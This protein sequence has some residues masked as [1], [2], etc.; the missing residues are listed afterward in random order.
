CVVESSDE[1]P[2]WT[3]AD[4]AALWRSGLVE[5]VSAGPAELRDLTRNHPIEQLRIFVQLRLGSLLGVPIRSASDHVYG[6]LCAAYEKPAAWNVDDLEMLQ[7]FA[8]LAASDLELRRRVDEQD[9]NEQRLSY[10]ANHDAL[11]GLATRA[12]LLERLRVALERPPAPVTDAPAISDDRL[13]PPP[14]DLVAV[15]M[16]DVENFSAIS[17]RFGPQAGDQVLTAIAGRLRRA[18]GESLVARCGRDQFAVLVERLETT[19]AATT[20]SERLR[21]ALEQPLSVGGEAVSLGARVGISLSAT[22]ATLAE[23]VLHRAEVAV[24]QSEPPVADDNEAAE[25]HVGRPERS[26]EP[27]GAGPSL[28]SGRQELP[29]AP[30]EVEPIP[31]SDHVA[32]RHR[33]AKGA[34]SERF[35]RRERPRLGLFARI[36]RSWR[37]MTGLVR[38][39]MEFAKLDAGEVALHCVD[40]NVESL[41]HDLRQRVVPRTYAKAIHFYSSPCASDVMVRADPAKLRRVLHHLVAN[42]IKF[43]EPGGEISVECEAHH[44][45]VRICVRDT[46]RGIPA[47]WLTQVFEPY[48]QVDAHLMPRGQRGLGLGLTISQRLATG[49]GGAL[50][51]ESEVGKGSAFTL[52]LLRA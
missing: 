2:R 5:L 39:A 26:E 43:T 31:P 11:T 36:G 40:V 23:H 38:N 15:F 34:A 20:E 42:A 48:V 32:S 47:S 41:L 3:S 17:A 45:A 24:A 49:M 33:T 13:A 12:V 50:D 8:R 14:E 4:E 18:A 21:A 37:S 35:L 6:V 30:A 10:Y 52:T 44:Q 9:A 1:I 51:A 7:Q 16:V 25:G 19:E 46:G 28:P 22:T 29:P 27:A